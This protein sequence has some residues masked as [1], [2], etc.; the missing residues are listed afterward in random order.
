MA[1][2]GKLPG[3]EN[4]SLSPIGFPWPPLAK[5]LALILA[6]ACR[7]PAAWHHWKHS[8][9]HTNSLVVTCVLTHVQLPYETGHV[10]VLEIEWQQI[11]GK[12][13][14]V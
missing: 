12:L 6:P 1:A 10:A 11:F 3:E 7:L 9:K 14:L 8:Q 2:T 5:S 13:D 4:C